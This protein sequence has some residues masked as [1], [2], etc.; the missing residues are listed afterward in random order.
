MY[1]KIFAQIYDGSLVANW[2]ALV[3]FQQFIVL[4]S[5]DGIVDMTPHAMSARTGIPFDIISEG[6]A[7]LEQPDQ[8]S[9]SPECDGRRIQRL[10]DHRV[11]GWR[12]VNHDKYMRTRD[13]AAKREYD[14]NRIAKLRANDKDDIGTTKD[15]KYD[16]KTTSSHSDSDSDLDLDLKAKDKVASPPS[17]LRPPACPVVDL[18]E[19]YNAICYP[20]VQLKVRTKTRDAHVAARWRQVFIDGAA[21][22]HAEGL[23]FFSEFFERVKQ[24]R[25][26]TGRSPSP[27][28][29]PP[30]RASLDWLMNPQNFAKVI[31]G[32]Y[33]DELQ[34]NKV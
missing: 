14:R 23:Q 22:T 7:A 1:G 10:D 16:K 4:A 34:R 25:F 20:C 31:E 18:I 21:A 32:K 13:F 2:K 17:V 15:D 19:S 33:D 30:F 29:R 27:P 26:L 12:I 5:P 9:R 24:S 6:I 11:W 28:G 8:Y 3:T